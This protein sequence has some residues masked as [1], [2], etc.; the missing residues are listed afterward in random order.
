MNLHATPKFFAS[1]S[2]GPSGG[3]APGR[4]LPALAQF[5]RFVTA[6]LARYALAL[7]SQSTLTRLAW[8]ALARLARSALARLAPVVFALALPG[9]LAGCASDWE[10]DCK[11][12]VMDF[13]RIAGPGFSVQQEE[14][15]TKALGRSLTLRNIYGRFAVMPPPDDR[16]QDK[17]PAEILAA[18]KPLFWVSYHIGELTAEGLPETLRSGKDLLAGRLESLHLTDFSYTVSESR[19]SAESLAR[20]PG[21]APGAVRDG[22]FGSLELSDLNLDADALALML[23]AEHARPVPPLTG[24]N[25]PEAAL[26]LPDFL[27]LFSAAATEFRG[28]RRAL[29]PLLV[30]AQPDP[31][32]NYQ[33]LLHIE[34]G[35]TGPVRPGEVTGARLHQ[36]SLRPENMPDMR[37][38]T[39]GELSFERWESGLPF[40][41]LHG[42]EN[43]GPRLP[44]KVERCTLADLR[45]DRAQRQLRME[46]LV[47]SAEGSA[48]NGLR[49]D[50]D[51]QGLSLPLPVLAALLGVDAPP[52][53]GAAPL[54]LSARYRAAYTREEGRGR[55]VIDELNLAAEGLFEYRCEGSFANAAA[56]QVLRPAR[57]LHAPTGVERLQWSLTDTG[58]VSLCKAMF[59]GNGK[60][61]G[62]SLKKALLAVGPLPFFFEADTRTMN[63]FMGGNGTLHTN[64]RPQRPAMV[65]RLAERPDAKARKSLGLSARFAKAKAK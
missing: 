58:F 30:F 62:A 20:S 18:S 51:M 40:P 37:I 10:K 28:H 13:S 36:V 45:M 17:S 5:T 16:P 34:R 19:D 7:F 11:S 60:N 14:P 61:A 3:R 63:T 6:R 29:P 12:A 65:H 31:L 25:Q 2:R 26:P 4:T 46:S 8:P 22:F 49:L 21:F 33:S 42:L 50:L 54:T 23:L 35:V 9:L 56:V 53:E 52:Q 64:V 43:A 55:Y 38:L 47:F 1:C 41:P 32:V 15:R 59:F 39:L 24:K 44:W 48:D 27:R 57:V